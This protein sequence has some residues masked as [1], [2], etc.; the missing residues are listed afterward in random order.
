MVDTTGEFTPQ[1][2]VHPE[3]LAEQTTRGLIIVAERVLLTHPSGRCV[4]LKQQTFRELASLGCTQ[5]E[6]Y[7]A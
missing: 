7:G 1:D 4:A 6:P 3:M 2:M 5:C